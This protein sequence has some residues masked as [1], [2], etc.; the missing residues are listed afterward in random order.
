MTMPATVRQPAPRR[1]PEY[2]SPRVAA[3]RDELRRAIDLRDGFDA[4]IDMMAGWPDADP[5]AER[6]ID[7]C[8]GQ[9]IDLDHYIR[10]VQ[11]ALHVAVTATGEAVI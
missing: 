3:L 5:A 8:V 10:R 11:R 9:S 7:W 4:E 6:R 2:G 1:R